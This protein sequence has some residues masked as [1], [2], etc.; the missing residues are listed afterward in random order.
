MTPASEFPSR[1]RWGRWL[2]RPLD[3]RLGETVSPLQTLV[4]LSVKQVQC[5]ATGHLLGCSLECS[6]NPTRWPRQR[7]LSPV[8]PT[9]RGARRRCPGP[10]R[11]AQDLGGLNSFLLHDP[12]RWLLSSGPRGGGRRARSSRHC[13]GGRPFP[14]DRRTSSPIPKAK[15]CHLPLPPGNRGVFLC[16][17]ILWDILFYF[18]N[19]LTV[20]NDHT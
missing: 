3:S 20:F 9:Q 15:V 13:G 18:K 7:G 8:P 1:L 12:S 2:W 4:S 5:P 16:L 19:C 11:S 6:R 14:E 10:A 17:F